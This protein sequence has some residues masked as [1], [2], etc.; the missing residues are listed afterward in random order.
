VGVGKGVYNANQGGFV[1]P[2]GLLIDKLQV[3]EILH[4]WSDSPL[5]SGD[6]EDRLI[7]ANLKAREHRYTGNATVYYALDPKDSMHEFRM[8]FIRAQRECDDLAPKQDSV[9]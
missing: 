7:F 5:P 3:P 1:R 6:C 4:L 9:R 2:S 8:K